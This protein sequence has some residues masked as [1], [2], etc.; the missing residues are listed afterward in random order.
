M[1]PEDTGQGLHPLFQT[2]QLI[3]NPSFIPIEK[4]P[5]YVHSTNYTQNR[6]YNIIKP[7]LPPASL[8]RLV[9]DGDSLVSSVFPAG[10]QTFWRQV[11]QARQAP[12][13]IERAIFVYRLMQ[14]R[15]CGCCGYALQ[16][17][18]QLSAKLLKD[19]DL[20]RWS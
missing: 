7:T 5:V 20:P 18:C 8:A 1:S 12:P 15:E 16:N 6:G 3:F 17:V 2:I 10:H 14:S 13:T 11:L 19:M 9:Q 4:W